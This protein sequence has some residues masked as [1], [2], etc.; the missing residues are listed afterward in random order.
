MPLEILHAE[1]N[2][3]IFSVG[4]FGQKDAPVTMV[5][6][7]RSNASH[8]SDVSLDIIPM[9]EEI[10]NTDIASLWNLP[11]EQLDNPGIDDPFGESREVELDFLSSMVEQKPGRDL[12][13]RS[14]INGQPVV[15]TGYPPLFPLPA[16][17]LD[18]LKVF[19]LAGFGRDF[20]ERLVSLIRTER[21]LTNDE[22]PDLDDETVAEL[23]AL[24]ATG[25]N[26]EFKRAAGLFHGCRD[27][28]TP[29]AVSW[30]A[31]DQ[32]PG[33]RQ[34]AARE[35]PLLTGLLATEPDAREA[36]DGARPLLS[37][38]QSVFPNLTKGGLRR[39]RKIVSQSIGQASVC[40]LNSNPLQD[41]DLL[42]H[43]HERSF[44]LTGEW[45]IKDAIRALTDTGNPSIIPETSEE[46]D[47]F[48]T[49]Y[50]GFVR[51]LETSLGLDPG[52]AIQ[53]SKGHWTRVLKQLSSTLELPDNKCLGRHQAV[54]LVTDL[55]EMCNQL[56]KTVFLP[57]M[58]A[59]VHDHVPRELQRLPQNDWPIHPDLGRASFHLAQN[60]LLGNCRNNPLLHC[61]QLIR[62]WAPRI[63]RLDTIMASFT[64]Q[65]EN[66]ENVDQ[67][68]ETLKWL[69]NP[70]TA[71]PATDSLV[72]NGVTITPLNTTSSLA[73]EGERMKHCL[74]TYKQSLRQ[75]QN[76]FYH[77]QRENHNATLCL[78]VGREGSRVLFRRNGFSAERNDPPHRILADAA[79]RFTNGLNDGQIEIRGEFQRWQEWASSRTMDSSERKDHWG[80]LANYCCYPRKEMNPELI[81]SSSGLLPLT[82]Q[83][84]PVWQEI[85]RCPSHPFQ[86]IAEQAGGNNPLALL[87]QPNAP[88]GFIDKFRISEPEATR[89]TERKSNN[90]GSRQPNLN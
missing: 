30:Y 16:N 87:V 59:M 49:L 78:K 20:L 24:L 48:A 42:G 53:A 71:E 79:T 2:A 55:L 29:E 4:P 32:P 38:L 84:W 39:I 52:K 5:C 28:M 73:K 81:E 27:E 64:P 22:C 86:L 85:A 44:V 76:V 9:P 8:P 74:A 60:V 56:A 40:D 83:L 68:E 65:E 35:Y 58:T 37:A 46:W 12:Q 23:D 72:V 34:Q 13:R 17:R 18:D 3:K 77:L 19:C 62:R 89:V 6:C 57:A 82:A 41:P 10:A 63:N 90:P 75:G 45:Q 88:L 61:C 36:V 70:G 1:D 66:T 51:P 15:D 25:Y 47:A 11:E 67:T 14:D 43:I 21:G 54:V 33:W 31:L 69:K 7:L 50:G 26:R 80:L